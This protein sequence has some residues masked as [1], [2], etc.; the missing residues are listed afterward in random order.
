METLHEFGYYARQTVW[1]FIFKDRKLKI[2]TMLLC[3][4]IADMIKEA[5][6]AWQNDADLWNNLLWEFCTCV[7]YT[8]SL[9]LIFENSYHSDFQIYHHLK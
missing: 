3:D 1:H 2:Y 6:A 5:S 7:L 8:Y 9:A 4:V